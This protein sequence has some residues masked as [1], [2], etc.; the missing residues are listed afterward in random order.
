M[1]KS[2]S[3]V[4]A[5]P[6]EHAYVGFGSNLGSG[7]VNFAAAVAGIAAR[8]YEVLRQSSLYRSEPWGGA[9]GGDFTNAVLEVRRRGTARG[10]LH[11]LLTL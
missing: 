11:D 2:R 1:S 5:E 8:G 3:P 7:A 10:F 6:V 4:A 9:E